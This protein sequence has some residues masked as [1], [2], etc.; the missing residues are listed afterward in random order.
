MCAGKEGLTKWEVDLKEMGAKSPMVIS[1]ETKNPL[2][3]ES[4][5][6]NR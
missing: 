3:L 1:K 5:I 4:F 6:K 2:L